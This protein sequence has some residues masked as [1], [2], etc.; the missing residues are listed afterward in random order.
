MVTKTLIEDQAAR[1][2]TDLYRS[3]SGMSQNNVSTVTLRGFAQDEILY[4]G[5][6][7]NPF[8]NFSI[9]Q[10]FTIEQVQV[11]KGPSGAIYGAGEP[12]GVINYVTKKPTYEQQNTLQVTAGNKDFLSGSIESSNH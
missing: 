7:G 10:L 5:L 1:Q 6:K 3:I 12:G 2:I 9:P 8:G 4:D 11:L